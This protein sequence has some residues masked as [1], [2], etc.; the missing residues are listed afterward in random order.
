MT[1][2]ASSASCCSL[3]II[4]E[5]QGREEIKVFRSA[6]IA[7]KRGPFVEASWPPAAPV[8]H[9]AC[10]GLLYE[11]EIFRLFESTPN[12]IK[13]I[14]SAFF[15]SIL[16]QLFRRFAVLNSMW[17]RQPADN[18]CPRKKYLR[19]IQATLRRGFAPKL[20]SIKFWGRFSNSVSLRTIFFPDSRSTHS[21][22]MLIRIPRKILHNMIYCQCIGL[23]II[24]Y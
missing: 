21:I 22:L 11:S 7:H 14:E 3:G 17:G 9:Y 1:S 10:S 16:L 19:Q 4:E 24:W 8:V 12:Q 15:S 20:N 18:L 5:Y 6:S 2:A 13:C 23:H